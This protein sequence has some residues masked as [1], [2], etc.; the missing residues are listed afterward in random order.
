ME[1]QFYS[2]GQSFPDKH[3]ISSRDCVKP[4]T[5]PH[6]FEII[7]TLSNLSREEK[8]AIISDKFYVSLFVYKQ[9]PYVVFDFNIY[10]CNVAINI[11]KIR[12]VPMN[13]WLKAEEESIVIYLLEEVSGR[14]LGIRLCKFPLMTE[15]KYLLC[16][17]KRL[18]REVIDNRISEGESINTVQDMLNYS[19]F[20]GVV[21]ESG[22]I[23]D[24]TMEVEEDII[25]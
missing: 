1:I 21:S 20:Y 22:V 7:M 19:I 11:Q 5:T 24:E 15:L 8:K 4:R 14:I 12:Q 6:S 18:S 17:Q 23:L 13:E 16:L 25:F 3:Y 10:K 9:I 2:L